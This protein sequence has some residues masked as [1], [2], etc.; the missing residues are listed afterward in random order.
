MYGNETTYLQ[1][2]GSTYVFLSNSCDFYA[3]NLNVSILFAN[4]KTDASDCS[5][6]IQEYSKAMN[7]LA[8]MVEIKPKVVQ[9]FNTIRDKFPC[10]YEAYQLLAGSVANFCFRNKLNL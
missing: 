9:D 7:V 2:I 8:T 5:N 6:K 3:I 1:I 4:K 10:N